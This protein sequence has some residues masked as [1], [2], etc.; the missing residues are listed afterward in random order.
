LPVALRSLAPRGLTTQ[1]AELLIGPGAHDGIS[2]G[3]LTALLLTDEAGVSRLVDRLESKG[4]VRRRANDRDRRTRRLELT[5][6]GRALVA[7]MRRRRATANRR[8]RAGI[9]DDEL[10]QLSST[11]LRLSDNMRTM[12]RIVS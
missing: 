9:S 1:Q 2:A 6:L 10:A 5:P 12:Q 4:F 3:Q 7:R 11:L 8:F